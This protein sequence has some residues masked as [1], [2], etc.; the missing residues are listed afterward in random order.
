MTYTILKGSVIY[1]SKNCMDTID[2]KNSPFGYT[3]GVIGGKW[4][5]P[6]LYLLSDYECIRYNELQRL[7]QTITYKTLSVQLKELNTDG[8]ICR[9]EYPQIPPKVE[10]RLSEKGKTILPILDEICKWGYE[11]M[12]DF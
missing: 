10:Y 12:P 3:L 4:K 7:L 6:I 9:K 2:L 8:L 5:M 11:N 1:M